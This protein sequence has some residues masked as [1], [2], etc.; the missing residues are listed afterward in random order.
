MLNLTGRLM[1]MLL[2]CSASTMSYAEDEES[3]NPAQIYPATPSAGQ[4]RIQSQTRPLIVLPPDALQGHTMVLPLPGEPPAAVILKRDSV[5]T[6]PL[7]QP[8][9][10]KSNIDNPQRKKPLDPVVY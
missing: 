10:P 3:D 7:T 4:T 2:A 6:V 1:C 8:P 9:L 5:E